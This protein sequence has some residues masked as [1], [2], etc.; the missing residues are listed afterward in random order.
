VDAAW[1]DDYQLA[2]DYAD[3]WL[4]RC[5]LDTG[6]WSAGGNLAARLADDPAVTGIARFVAATALG[7]LR[8]RRGDPGTWAALDQALAIARQTGHL[9]RMWPVA[10]A[11]AE[12]AWLEGRIEDEVALLD[13]V[14]ALAGRLGYPWAIGEIGFWRWR[15][16]AADQVP[17]PSVPPYRLQAGDDPAAA[18]AEWDRLGCPY[19][20]AMARADSDDRDDVRRAFVV[21]DALGAR[22]VLRRVAARLRGLGG[23][24]PRSPSA[25]TRRHPLGLTE[26]EAEVAG[27]VRLGLTNREVA[28]RLFL[29]DKTVEHHVSAVLAKLGLRTRRELR[30]AR[31]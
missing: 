8:A 3:A 5:L 1:A 31:I 10:A 19:E 7:R 25:A 14:Q 23:A 22:P 12:A 6:E 30:S 16:G 27:P 9:Q 26:R 15:A 29:S 28:A 20:A 2:R 21:L 17:E 24:V 4:S 11:R 18:A 13:E